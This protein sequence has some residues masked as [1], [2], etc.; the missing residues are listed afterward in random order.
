MLQKL[1][2]I[3]TAILFTLIFIIIGGVG[4]CVF[5]Y[6]LFGIVYLI[7]RLFSGDF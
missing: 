6:I 4:T 3:A 1:R 2:D 7:T 5:L